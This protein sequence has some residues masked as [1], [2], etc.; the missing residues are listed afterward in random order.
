M[1]T[2]S[3]KDQEIEINT[4]SPPS[5]SLQ[6]AKSFGWTVTNHCH[7]PL[8]HVGF[9]Q[10]EGIEGFG[11]IQLLD[12][13]KNHCK[14]FLVGKGK[15]LEHTAEAFGYGAVKYEVLKNNRLT[16][17]T[18]SFDDMLKEM[19]NNAVY[20]Q[21]THARICLSMERSDKSLMESA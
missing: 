19:G 6:A 18:F 14:A 16:D 7:D 1:I 3:K 10:V 15:E 21:K 2:S 17:Y 11:L 5:S 20:L 4:Y 8:S 13:A 9:V 12:E